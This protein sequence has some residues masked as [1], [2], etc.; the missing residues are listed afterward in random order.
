MRR[1]ANRLEKAY[2]VRVMQK[3][4]KCSR[5]SVGARRSFGR[6]KKRVETA[7]LVDLIGLHL[8]LPATLA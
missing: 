2:S 5:Q 1:I 7:H 6:N 8:G 3:A 4:L